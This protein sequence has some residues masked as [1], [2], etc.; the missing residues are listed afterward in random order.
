MESSKRKGKHKKKKWRELQLKLLRKRKRN[1]WRKK[2]RRGNSKRKKKKLHNKLPLQPLLQKMRK[3]VK[4]KN[5]LQLA[6]RKH[7][8]PKSLLHPPLKM[9]KRRMRNKNKKLS[10]LNYMITLM[11]ISNQSWCNSGTQQYIAIK[12]ICLSPLELSEADVK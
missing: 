7:K 2:K 10:N 9:R 11:M 1:G 5:L 4:K 6:I 8:L 12:T 3:R